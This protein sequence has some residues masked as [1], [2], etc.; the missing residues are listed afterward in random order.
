MKNIY[1]YLFIAIYGLTFSAC[2]SIE[3]QFEEELVEIRF[4]ATTEYHTYTKTTLE[5]EL[6]GGTHQILWSPGDEIAIIPVEAAESLTSYTFKNISSERSQTTVFEGESSNA[7]TYYA[8]YPAANVGNATSGKVVFTLPDILTYQPGSF[9]DSSF[10]MAA[11]VE[12]GNDISFNNLCG[13]LALRLTGKETIKSITFVADNDKMVAG[14]FSIDMSEGE[15]KI[16]QAGNNKKSI[17]MD[18]GPEG[19]TLNESEATVFYF[20]LPPRT[21]DNFDILIMTAD[22]GMM[23]KRAERPLRIKRSVLTP[24]GILNYVENYGIDLSER[25]CS[26]SYVIPE[27]GLY[28]FDATIIGN[29]EFGLLRNAGFH[30]DDVNINPESVELLWTD[31]DNLISELNFSDGKVRFY[32][33]GNEG[34]AFLAVKDGDDNIL[35]SWHLWFTDTPVE[36][37]YNNSVGTFKVLDRNLGATR[38]DRGTGD[39]WKESSGLVY[40]WGRKDPFADGK[41]DMIDVALYMKEIISMPTT[42]VVRKMPWTNEWSNSFWDS[43][44]KTIYDPCPVGYKVAKDEIWADFTKTGANVDRRAQ[45]NASGSFDYGWNFY[46]DGENTAWYPATPHIGYSGPYEYHTDI[47]YCWKSNHNSSH[48][49]LFE[50]YYNSDMKCHVKIVDYRTYTYQAFPVRCMKDDGYLDVSTY[51]E[52]AIPEVSETSMTTAKINSDTKYG[53]S[54]NITEKGFI[55]GTAPDLSDGTK[56]TCESGHGKFSYSLNGLSPN[57]TY[58]VQSY[59]VAETGI[60]YSEIIGFRTYFSDSICGYN[61]SKDSTANCYIVSDSGDYAF[62]GSVKGNSNESV[63]SPVKVEVLWESIS[64]TG[65]ADSGTIISSVTLNGPYVQFNVPSPLQE[66]NALIAVKDAEGTVLWSWHIWVT[67]TPAEHT[68]VNSSGTFVVLDRNLGATRADRGTGDEWKQSCGIDFFWGRK[69]PFMAYCHSEIASSHTIDESVKNPTVKANGWGYGP[70]SDL[71][72]AEHKTM[73]DPCPAGYRV[74]KQEIWNGFSLSTVSGK[75]E[76]G[77]YC[78]YNGTDTAW[79]PNRAHHQPACIDYWG[80]NYMTAAQQYSG[81]YSSSGH[82]LNNRSVEYA[83]L[84]CMKE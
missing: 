35:W 83:T 29:G 71:W 31:R 15:W 23:C 48:S 58:Y 55:Y 32:A 82:V 34:N 22:G 73:Y 49:N 33:T 62:D 38:A 80:D 3:E 67:D 84:R 59:I 65:K 66:G 36:Q 81:L 42:Y 2:L 50:Y 78:I 26:N 39:E 63:T 8:F 24:A 14:L 76:N 27:A 37:T 43:E 51:I 45:I 60:T 21:Y 5:G 69:D 75:F 46:I 16:T 40:Q 10:P 70:S 56:V 7:D 12:S 72:S 44:T 41:Y 79:Y 1:R 77:W 74:A 52:L 6:G 25:G 28:S 4:T 54:L 53:F 13:L 68:Y 30:T 18:C 64:C 19:V 57:T 61:L 11:K 47:G 9:T 20:I 17:V